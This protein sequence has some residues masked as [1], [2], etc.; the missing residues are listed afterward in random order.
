MVGGWIFI[1][2]DTGNFNEKFPSHFSFNIGKTCLTMSLHEDLYAF[3]APVLLKIRRREKCFWQI[4]QTLIEY[5]FYI[6]FY[7]YGK[8]H[9]LRGN[10]TE[11]VLSVHFEFEYSTI[12]FQIDNLKNKSTTENVSSV[13]PVL[14]TIRF[15]LFLQCISLLKYD[16]EAC[17]QHFTL[18]HI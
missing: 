3:F 1:K 6:H 4:S 8:P 16:F 2:F 11:R 7:F 13:Y 14:L 17:I 10:W 9:T 12:I 18:V 5:G 15:A